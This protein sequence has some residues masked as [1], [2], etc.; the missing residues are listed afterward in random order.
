MKQVV[1]LEIEKVRKGKSTK[2]L[3][4]LQLI[5]RE[6][7]K[8]YDAPDVCLS[9]PQL[10]IDSWDYSDELGIK[11]INLADWYKRIK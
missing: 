5:L 6:L 8:S 11:L 1:K 7:E 9:F 10:I 4:Q 2:S 3:S